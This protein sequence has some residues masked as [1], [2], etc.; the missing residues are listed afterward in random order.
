MLS[1]RFDAARRLSVCAGLSAAAL[2]AAAGGAGAQAN[3]V[4][5]QWFEAGWDTLEY[6]MPDAFV[7]G[8]GAYWI[9][10]IHKT[11]DPSSA[12][13]DQFS[14]FDLGTPASPTLYGTERGFRY[15]MDQFRR[16]NGLVYVDLVMNHCSG[17]DGSSGFI[18]Q[19]GYP[20]FWFNPPPS[21]N[22]S[23]GGNW[24]DFHD[25]TTQS[26][27]PGSAN[28]NLFDG[29][30]VSLIDINQYSQN[31][32]IRNPVNAAL[33]TGVQPSANSPPVNIPGGTL[34]NTVDPANA[35]FYPDL[36][37]TPTVVN[38]PGYNRNACC[39]F[40]AF[41]APASSL[42]VYPFN[43][44]SP[45]GV[46]PFNTGTAS[47]GDAVMENANGYLLRSTQWLLEEFRVDGFRLDAAKHIPPDWWDG[48]W[49]SIVYNRRVTPSGARVTPFSFGEN[50]LGNDQNWNYYVR[51]NVPARPTETF[52]NR[53]ALDLNGAGTIRNQV[54]NPSGTTWNS[55]LSSHLD[56]ADDADN[57][58]S[59]GMN[60]IFSHD[61]GSAGNGSSS[62]PLPPLSNA[63]WP[64]WAYLLLRPGP[65]IVYHNARQYASFPGR[66]PGNF[67]PREGN[68]EALGLARTQQ[69]LDPTLTRLVTAANQFGRGQW[70][71]KNL[72]TNILTFERWNGN[73]GSP[74]SNVLVAS[75]TWFHNSTGGTT[76]YDQ[77]IVSTRFIN[78][79]FLYDV[80]GNADDPAIDPK[81]EIDNTLTVG[82][83]FFGLS[84]GQVRLRIPRNSSIDNSSVV[85]THYK[86][87]IVYAP[88][89]PQ[90]TL[91]IQRA[92]GPV[93][94][95]D[96]VNA[97]PN[98][99]KVPAARR[100]NTVDVVQSPTFTINLQTTPRIANGNPDVASR[101]NAAIFRIDQG[102][103]DFNGNGSV[104]VTSGEFA[105]SENFATVNSPPSGGN[106]SGNYQQ[107]INTD[108]L[109]DGY[110][111]IS[112]LAFRGRSA[113]ANPIYT[114][115]RRVI[116]VDR[117]DPDLSMQVSGITCTSR[118]G[119]LMFTNLDGTVTGVY[120]FLNQPA[121]SLSPSN[122]ASFFDRGQWTFNLTNLP[123][124][125][126]YVTVVIQRAP[127][128]VVLRQKTLTFDLTIGGIPGDVDQNGV[129]N[130]EDLYAIN[131]L[132]GYLCQADMD[133]N[134]VVNA[135]DITLLENQLRV[136]ETANMLIGR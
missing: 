100:I 30:L 128:G 115:F 116:Y 33:P 106:N 95:A 51:K 46:F 94:P 45:S 78:G 129:V 61:N 127:S 13:F 98:S 71:V 36:A 131:Q 121:G 4:Y 90:G 77:R 70:D 56:N 10:P 132:S 27:D 126:N 6:R 17:R 134:G 2:L 43:T 73:A 86:G 114:D 32:T 74:E 64:Q 83:S 35:R 119:Q 105:G 53:D 16:A 110:H 102:F 8:Y 58:G 87:F 120:V 21:G 92:Q 118:N 11:R 12:G 93:L 107:I 41:S 97:N 79:T 81:N 130:R 15:L 124:G 99:G 68:P 18:A 47:A 26:Q 28:Y 29:D 133:G 112:A 1:R 3:P 63:A 59:I 39:G 122:L 109:T 89:T 66:G 49:D 25:G 80:T 84:P 108:S 14:K 111:Y 42:T 23:A 104:D 5:L 44:G 72:E 96:D 54:F 65:V 40:G 125:V 76:N 136:G 31:F 37:L 22:K 50:V 24:G 82:D 62:P 60:H 38:N 91:T 69:G 52:G 7:A 57:N 55:V 117:Q 85:R 20:G 123:R 75:D 113:A 9:P 48:S 101:G 88:G 67:W 103:R 19:G 135:A 34:Y